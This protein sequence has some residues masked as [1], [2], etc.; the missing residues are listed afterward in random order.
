MREG[1]RTPWR[2]AVAAFA[3]VVALAA[4]WATWQ[5]LRAVDTG[6][7]ALAQLDNAGKDP[8]AFDRARRLTDDARR[9]N[10]ISVEPLFERNV[11]ETIAGDK[12]AAR[13]ALEEAVRL[14]PSN[15]ATW[16]ALT[17]FMLEQEDRPVQAL[18]LLGPA[19]YLDPK[20]AEGAAIYLQ[21]LRRT[22]EKQAAR[23]EARR[24][25]RARGQAKAKANARK[26]AAQTP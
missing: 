22:A 12:V 1:L 26:R 2:A 4:A 24:K 18:R 9:R 25:A 13:A 11:I 23:T 15:P 21:A 7:E 3:L 6:N 20:A 10:P 16:M 17:R 8:H 19:L 5:P 14:Q